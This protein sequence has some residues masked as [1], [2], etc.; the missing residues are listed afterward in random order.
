MNVTRRCYGHK[1]A[2]LI[3]QGDGRDKTVPPTHGRTAGHATHGHTDTQ[4]QRHE[5]STLYAAYM[6]LGG[7]PN[8]LR[9]QHATD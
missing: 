4:T 7:R 9:G 2:L 1:P 3:N 8:M 6:R 5:I